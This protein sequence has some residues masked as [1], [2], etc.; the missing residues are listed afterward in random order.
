[1]CR[2]A[3]ANGNKTLIPQLSYDAAKSIAWSALHTSSERAFVAGMQITDAT[4]SE[5][6]WSGSTWRVPITG[7]ANTFKDTKM[8]DQDEMSKVSGKENDTTPP[9]P[10][11]PENGA[12]NGKGIWPKPVDP[13]KNP[14]DVF[15]DNIGKDPKKKALK[16][17]KK[18][19]TRGQFI[20]VRDKKDLGKEYPWSWE[21]ISVEDVVH[22]LL[23]NC[24]KISDE[25]SE[26]IGKM[27]KFDDMYNY[28]EKRVL[29]ERNQTEVQ[30]QKWSFQ[31]LL[32]QCY[33]AIPKYLS[34]YLWNDLASKLNSLPDQKRIHLVSDYDYMAIADSKSC[35]VFRSEDGDI[36]V[37]AWFLEPF[38]RNKDWRRRNNYL[39]ENLLGNKTYSYSWIVT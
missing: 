30:A 19:V 35:W 3:F 14:D 12:S 22:D 6:T 29:Q 39:S 25:D 28:L 27:E 7:F 31:R 13:E 37:S 32:D 17:K 33:D 21:L 20:D 38:V 2:R 23:H 9:K 10:I 8:E 26:V 18:T 15:K 16:G 11:D 4:V 36:Y 24:S 1:M 5:V 34:D